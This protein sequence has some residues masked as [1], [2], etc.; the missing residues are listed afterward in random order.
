MHHLLS[1]P[2]IPTNLKCAAMSAILLSFKQVLTKK[3]DTHEISSTPMK[4]VLTTFIKS[5]QS[6]LKL[7]NIMKQLDF[8]VIAAD[9]TARVFIGDYAK[10]IFSLYDYLDI[11]L[12]QIR[13]DLDD[14]VWITYTSFKTKGNPD[15]NMVQLKQKGKGHVLYQQL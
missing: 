8:T 10:N 6:R 5:D 2:L 15:I 4:Y 1:Q 7:E 11:Q 13:F 12:S 3:T 14:A 9:K